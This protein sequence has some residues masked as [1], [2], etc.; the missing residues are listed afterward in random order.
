MYVGQFKK[1][2]GILSSQA[3]LNFTH[4]YKYYVV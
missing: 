4:T 2:H 1:K 3:I